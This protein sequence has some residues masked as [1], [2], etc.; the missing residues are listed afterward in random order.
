MDRK[1]QSFSL[2]IMI[3]SLCCISCVLTQKRD[4]ERDF[5]AA[6]DTTCK[7]VEIKGN[8]VREIY[9]IDPLKKLSASG[10]PMALIRGWRDGGVIMG[11][12]VEIFKCK[13]THTI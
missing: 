12:K 10:C 2:A 8:D 4:I 1:G 5:I 11:K 7:S 3:A 6:V 9:V 13:D